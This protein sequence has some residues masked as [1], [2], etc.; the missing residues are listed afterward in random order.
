M[1]MEAALERKPIDK[2]KK[3]L[4]R[5]LRILLIYFIFI[6][7]AKYSSVFNNGIIPGDFWSCFVIV[8]VIMYRFLSI[9]MVPA[10]L[11]L[12]LFDLFDKKRC[13]EHK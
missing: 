13:S 7:I 1:P 6:Q 11:V 10:I 3:R 4:L 5:C 8:A 12:L 9:A 2:R